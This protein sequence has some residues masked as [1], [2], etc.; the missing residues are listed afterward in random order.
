[1]RFALFLLLFSQP[2]HVDLRDGEILPVQ[3]ALRTAPGARPRCRNDGAL[4]EIYNSILLYNSRKINSN[5]FISYSTADDP[6][7]REAGGGPG[8]GAGSD[9]QRIETAAVLWYDRRETG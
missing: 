9:G 7:A 4:P 3:S 8:T 6:A 2:S 1:M 5:L